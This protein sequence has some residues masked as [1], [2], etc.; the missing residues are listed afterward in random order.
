MAEPT[1]HIVT[2][3]LDIFSGRLF[4]VFFFEH[5]KIIG[6][7]SDIMPFILRCRVVDPL[8]DFQIFPTGSLQA[9]LDMFFNT[10]HTHA[11]L[12]V[13]SVMER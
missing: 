13:F 5:L 6:D 10:W 3:M 8:M 2:E 4:A 11:P 7:G 1:L 9:Y 12:L